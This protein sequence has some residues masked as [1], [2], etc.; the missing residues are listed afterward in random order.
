MFLLKHLRNLRIRIQRIHLLL[1]IQNPEIHLPAISQKTQTVRPL[2]PKTE[3]RGTLPQE[4]QIRGMS[5]LTIQIQTEVLPVIPDLP[6]MVLT[7][8]TLQDPVMTDPAIMAQ[9]A[10]YFL[11]PEKDTA[12][13]C[14]LFRLLHKIRTKI[15]WDSVRLISVQTIPWDFFITINLFRLKFFQKFL[16]FFLV[17]LSD[18]TF[19]YFVNTVAHGEYA[20]TMCCHDHSPMRLLF[21]DLT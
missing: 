20:W 14:H 6:I 19:T 21:N 15:P 9:A 18:F 4:R 5:L 7:K 17:Y 10:Q 13:N 1:T 12:T 11:R 3:L 8:E 2:L 16:D